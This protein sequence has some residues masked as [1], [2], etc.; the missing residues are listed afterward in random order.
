MCLV[1]SV[2]VGGVASISTRSGGIKP[3]FTNGLRVGVEHSTPL[4]FCEVRGETI[5]EGETP[6]GRELPSKSL[7]VAPTVDE[8]ESG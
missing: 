7:A 5:G 1:G 6:E 2:V 8:V 3:A 4:L